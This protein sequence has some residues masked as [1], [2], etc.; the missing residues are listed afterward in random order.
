VA[1]LYGRIVPAERRA[2]LTPLTWFVARRVQDRTWLTAV[3][4]THTLP[5]SSSHRRIQIALLREESH[6]MVEH[7]DRAFFRERE[8]DAGRVLLLSGQAMFPRPAH[9]CPCP[10]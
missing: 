1:K 5:L 4:W 6:G 8:S 2:A 9:Q 3:L 7:P 10:V